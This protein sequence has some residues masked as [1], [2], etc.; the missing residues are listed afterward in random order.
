MAGREADSLP[1][2]L[3]KHQSSAGCVGSVA[4]CSGRSG[5]GVAESHDAVPSE[6]NPAWG[7]QAD[8][9]TRVVEF[10]LA[11]DWTAECD[12]LQQATNCMLDALRQ[13]DVTIVLQSG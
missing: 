12:G 2:A 3:R 13:S 9:G 7:T 5:G 10:V 11:F 6:W 4:G 1:L 8:F